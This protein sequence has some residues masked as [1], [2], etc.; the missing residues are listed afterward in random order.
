VCGRSSSGGGGGGGGGGSGSF[1]AAFAA[2]LEKGLFEKVAGGLATQLPLPT[3]SRAPLAPARYCP[4][5]EAG[6]GRRA[7]HREK[8]DEDEDEE[9]EED[10]R[11]SIREFEKHKKFLM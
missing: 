9:E 3:S 5:I 1:T 11:G 10:S 6:R 4:M 7:P 2:L 8:E